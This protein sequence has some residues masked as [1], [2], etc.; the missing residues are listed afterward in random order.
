MGE[1]QL[2]DTTRS[3]AMN[4]NVFNT[5][6]DSGSQQLDVADMTPLK[7]YEQCLDLMTWP[8]T[9]VI[10]LPVISQGKQVKLKSYRWPA[11]NE[12]KGVV[13]LF[14]GYGS[15][16]PQLAIV[17]KY[18]AEAGY[19]CFGADMRGMGDSEGN[20]GIFEDNEQI[21]NDYWLLIFEAC[22]K[23][24]INQQSTPIYL[25][26]RSYGG[27]IATNMANS[28]IGRRMFAGIVNLTPFYRLFTE[29]LY[30]AYKYLVPL[31]YVHPNYIFQCEYVARDEA[32]QKK[33]K[34]IYEDDRNIG[35][36]TAVTARIWNEEQA[37]V[38]QSCQEAPQPMCFIEA[39]EDETVRND[40]IQEYAKLCKNNQSE[41]HVIEESDHTTICFDENHGS[42]MVRHTINFLDKVT[43]AKRQQLE[44]RS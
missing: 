9:D 43:E 8:E 20:R 35:F 30:Q 4:T 44:A 38:R 18:L 3:T 7:G 32:F 13:F 40:Y 15:H 39:K 31:C 1:T 37:K 41:Y 33:Y 25:W 24:Q 2:I 26:G 22:K 11:E 12:R 6:Y 28:T 17:A 36:F 16:A 23:F 5:E 19:E 10:D 27:L 21:Y 34:N 14:H 29:R 42:Q